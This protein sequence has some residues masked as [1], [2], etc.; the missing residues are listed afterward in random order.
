[1]L[2]EL[3]AISFLIICM[4]CEVSQT[5]EGPYGQVSYDVSR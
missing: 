2:V 1:M 4:S 5:L 3:K